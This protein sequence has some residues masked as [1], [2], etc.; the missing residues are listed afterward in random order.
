MKKMH[1]VASPELRGRVIFLLCALIL[2]RVGAH[3]PVP[4]VN[5]AALA[6]LYRG[7]SSNNIFGMLNMFS[8]GSL[9]RFSVFAIGVMPYISASIVMQLAAEVVPLLKSLKKE[10]EQGRKI[11]TKY[12]RVATI[13]FAAVQ[14][15]IAAAFVFE[16]GVVV[17]DKL[18]FF[19]SSV[20][21]LVGGTMFLMWLGEQITERGLGNG[22]S[23]I[24]TIGILASM[25]SSVEKFIVLCGERP[26]LSIILSLSILILVYFVV[27]FENALRKIPIHY[28]KGGRSL[29]LT[30]DDKSAYIPFKLNMA[31]VI[32]PIFASSIM[33]FPMILIG[34][35]SGRNVVSNNKLLAQMI[36]I[37][38]HGNLSY[39]LL[40]AACVIFFC[41]FYTALAFSPKEMAE[42]L[43]K[44]GAFVP[45]IRPGDQTSKYLEGVVIHLTLFG[46]LYIATICLI[47]E[48]LTLF[49]GVTF[50]FG[51]TSLLILVMVALEFNVQ[52]TSFRLNQHYDKLINSPISIDK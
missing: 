51:G 50:Y 11:I 33:S 31:G 9:E 7:G 15:I 14:S 4:G 47:P 29:H 48:L 37:L 40:F 16:Q 42:N 2:F 41:Y 49:D 35:I 18:E 8:G 43:K 30:R 45:N 44:S 27:F 28:A 19:V 10:G 36:G 24:I 39:I 32:P 17:V 6:E 46:S 25:P 38:Q 1:L 21:C 3:V 13:A 26:I 12:T 22:I 5:S 52:L 34:W 20:I 23:L